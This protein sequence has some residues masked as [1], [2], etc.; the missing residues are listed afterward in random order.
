MQLVE[1]KTKLKHTKYG[2]GIYKGKHSETGIIVEFPGH[3]EKHLFTT[4]FHN[5]FLEVI[6]EPKP[7]AKAITPQSVG[8]SATTGVIQFDTSETRIGD[9]NILESYKSNQTLIFNES[10]T[11]IGN[12]MEAKKIHACYN[13]TVVGDL[14]VQEIEIK[15]SLTVLGNLYA[16]QVLCQ[17][18]LCCKGKIEIDKG[19][20]GGDIIAEALTSKELYCG[21]NAI[22]QTTI[23]IENST[24]EKAMIAGEGIIGAGDF[25]AQNAIAVEYFEY[26]GDVKGKVLE[27]DTETTFGEKE[28]QADLDECSFAKLMDCAKTVL[29]REIF[30]AGEEDEET[31]LDFLHNVGAEA[32]VNVQEWYDIFNR[33]INISYQDSIENFRDYLILFYAQKI[34]PK[35]IQNY[36]TVEHIFEKPFEDAQAEGIELP[37]TVSDIKEFE[38]TLKIV[39]LYYDE[40]GYSKDELLDKMFQSIG[41]KYSTVGSFFV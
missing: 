12:V 6:E 14:R 9:Q 21:G 3:G 31:L 8:N 13:L 7:E 15:G 23:D 35:E 40:L 34:L 32:D 36:E 24:T 25:T 28:L 4:A 29:H 30:V 10:Y 16:S 11:I 26:S 37:F 18:D 33:V 38:I 19:E 41:I 17:N 39:L 27:L 5:G 2:I 20:I 1:N 22:V